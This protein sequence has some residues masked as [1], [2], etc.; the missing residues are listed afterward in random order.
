M[1][2]RVSKEDDRLPWRPIAAVA[3]AG[4]VVFFATLVAANLLLQTSEMEPRPSVPPPPSGTVMRTLIAITKPGLD[5][6]DQE[7]AS[8]AVYAWV[9]RDAGIASIP[10]ERAMDLVAAH[11]VA[12]DRS[13][14]EAR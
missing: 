13:I 6:R 10:I 8:L 14:E 7:R 1:S 2:Y 11:P 3:V 12:P 9:D 4:V 5:L